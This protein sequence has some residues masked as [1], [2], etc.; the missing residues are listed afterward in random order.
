MA[1]AP[2]KKKSAK[3]KA[4]PFAKMAAEMIDKPAK[5]KS[6]AKKKAMA[7]KPKRKKAA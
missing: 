4:S 2:K 6:P 5:G 1:K 3:A 7:K